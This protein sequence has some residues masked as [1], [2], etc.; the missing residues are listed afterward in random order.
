MTIPNDDSALIL[1][2][3]AITVTEATR[4]LIEQ[5]ATWAREG[6]TSIDDRAI[7]ESALRNPGFNVV[8]P[9][10]LRVAN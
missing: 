1:N 6:K 4:A 2:D 10:P 5:V 8:Q 9:R 7:A 3:S